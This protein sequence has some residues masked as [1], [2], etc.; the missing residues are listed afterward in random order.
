M[1]R[2]RDELTTYWHDDGPRFLH[3][4][5]VALATTLAMALCM[6]LEL[7]TPATAMVT[8]VIV[9]MHQQSGMVIAR[10]FYRGLGM[11]GGSFVGLALIALFPQQPL[12]FFV[13]L[14]AWLGVC[15]F[16]AS[17]FRNFQSYGFLLA[18][19]GTAITAVPV[20][21]NPYGVFD[22]IVFTVSEVV[23][24]V[25]C[26]CAVSAVVWPQSVTPTLFAVSR[27]SFTNLLNAVHATLGRPA[28]ASDTA[29]SAAPFPG[30]VLFLSLI[31]ERVGV[32]TLR[33]GAVFEDPSIR[34]YN[35]IFLKNDKRFFD[36][37]AW[38][39]ALQQLRT[40]ST[41]IASQFSAEAHAALEDLIGSVLAVVPETAAPEIISLQGVQTLANRLDDLERTLPVHLSRHL[42]SLDSVSPEQ[43]QLVATSGAA[44][45]FLIADLRML[46]RVHIEAR[47]VDPTPWSRSLFQTIRGF[48]QG[49]AT[50]N[51]IAA[52]VTGFRAAFATL[53]VGA[54]WIG[55]GWVGGASAIVAVAIA[56][57]LFALMPNPAVTTWQ[58]FCGCLAGWLAGFAFTFFL[59]PHL[60]GIVLLASSIAIFIM[61]GS[62]LNTF[63]KTAVMGLGFNIYFCFI[64]A[65]TNPTVYNPGGYLDTGF[66]LLCG[67]AAAAV[68]FSIVVPRADGWIAAQYV[69]QIRTSIARSADDALD[70]LLDKVESD[71]RDFILQIAPPAG[72]GNTAR[73]GLIQW[74]FAALEIG[75]AMVEVRLDTEQLG[76]TL[77]DGWPAA[78]RAWLTALADMFAAP[79]TQHHIHAIDATRHALHVLPVPVLTPVDANNDA[80]EG[81]H[82]AMYP[83]VRV[84]ASLLTHCRMRAL[85]H[86]TELIL[87]QEASSLSASVWASTDA[88]PIGATA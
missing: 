14:A 32:E 80:G 78:Q 75:R 43:R 53:L 72:A 18:G 41:Q 61:I 70:G 6:R 74:A 15:V 84:D 39:H 82:A 85:L 19:Y 88:Q 24:G 47:T 12:L 29:S 4:A 20:W 17:Y 40:P 25:C 48:G 38:L 23:I 69:N 34:L 58:I 71:L 11:I 64:V 30:L 77:P 7:R 45:F 68:A 33:S 59:L 16:T 35:S 49:G 37:V 1:N 3:M 5:K 65:I 13:G 76:D 28:P 21:S 26:A 63:A 86:F 67:I 55:S 87:R 62:Y 10:G 42:R 56:S 2:W 36:T 50:A 51:R 22:N 57:A 52:A 81:T 79:S 73:T 44:L 31:R 9:M 66:A 60:S 27:R 46:S 83:D 8:C 54:A